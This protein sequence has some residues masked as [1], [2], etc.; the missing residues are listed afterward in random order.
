MREKKDNKAATFRLSSQL[1]DELTEY[2]KR[3]RYSKSVVVEIA[4]ME[5]L[6]RKAMG[7]CNEIV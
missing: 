1:L 6:H 7:V 2:T 5:Y 3:T 4:L